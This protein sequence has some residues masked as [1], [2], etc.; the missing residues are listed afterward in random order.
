MRR[1]LKYSTLATVESVAIWSSEPWHQNGICNMNQAKRKSPSSVTP[2]P[3]PLPFSSAQQGRGRRG[4]GGRHEDWHVA[5]ANEQRLWGLL[6]EVVGSA[7]G[8]EAVAGLVLLPIHHS[9]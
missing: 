2:F 4:R 5:L 7:V 1:D 8:E 6:S 9:I 3:H